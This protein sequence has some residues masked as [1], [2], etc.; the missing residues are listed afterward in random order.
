M[1][2]YLLCGTQAMFPIVVQHIKLYDRHYKYYVENIPLQTSFNTDT[3]CQAP[4]GRLSIS[5][6]HG[7]PSP[8]HCIYYYHSVVIVVGGVP[9]FKVIR[10]SI[11][12]QTNNIEMYHVLL[13][14][15]TYDLKRLIGPVSSAG[16][17][18][19]SKVAELHYNFSP[20]RSLE[21]YSCFY[22]SYVGSVVPA[23]SEIYIH[24]II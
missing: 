5:K 13:S 6:K 9:W 18:S 7:H 11:W 14:N 2:H 15:M 4:C 23:Q 19:L 21:S 12:F 8:T 16:L 1:V 22:Y 3:I 20:N 17:Q 24:T 10:T